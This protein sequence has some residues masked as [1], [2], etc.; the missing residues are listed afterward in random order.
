MGIKRDFQTSA[1]RLAYTFGQN[2][3]GDFFRDLEI[4]SIYQCIGAG[5]GIAYMAAVTKTY[6]YI[7]IGVDELLEMTSGADVGAIA[8]NG[9]QLASDTGP[10]LRGDAQGSQE[11]SWVTGN[12]DAVGVEKGLPGDFD[13]TQ[14]VS[15]ELDVYS[16]TSDAATFTVATTWDGA[17]AVSD[18]AS[19]A[20]TKSATKH[21]ITATIAAADV[22]DSCKKVGLLLTPG[23]HGSD[24][25]QL[26]RV[27]IKYVRK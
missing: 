11:V 21:T 4:G 14:D 12:V 25:I 27:R 6:G 17:T 10:L 18:T 7:E 24:A 1:E 3:I 15:L 22:P 26:T 23:T 8:A 20:S 5:V 9:G 2:D 19:D 16:G 13:G